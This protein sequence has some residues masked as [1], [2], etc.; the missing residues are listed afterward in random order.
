MSGY[1]CNR[2]TIAKVISTG[3]SGMAFFEGNSC[4][5][6]LASKSKTAMSSRL[7][8]T[9]LTLSTIILL[10]VA[11]AIAAASEPA[12]LTLAPPSLDHGFRLLYD[13]KFNDAQQ[14]FTQWQQ[15]NPSDPMGPVSE[16]AGLLFSEFDRLGILESQ[17]FED[18]KTFLSGKKLSPDAAVH[19]RFEASL[20][21]AEG[22]AKT[23]LAKDPKDRDALLAMVLV[24]GLHADYAQLI[25]KRNLASLSYTRQGT[26]WAQQLLAVDPKAYDAYLA[27]GMSRYIIGSLFA[28]FRWFLHLGGVEGNKE[29]GLADLRLTAAHGRY[30]A[31]FARI[32]LAIACVR[33]KDK[34]QA[35]QLLAS[36][37][38]EF[39]ENG[40]FVREMQRLEPSLPQA[41]H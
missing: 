39:P 7:T 12:P 31:P 41:S 3:E 34:A 1:F 9:W 13:L 16:A 4:P 20:I 28:P 25:E 37:H 26:I 36:L 17:F 33:D 38:E 35:H 24:N 32:L 29:E 27:R 22:L 21:K 6:T 10:H 5:C 30:L 11:A 40:L 15:Q 23:D 8:N 2:G 18:D 14:E 19:S